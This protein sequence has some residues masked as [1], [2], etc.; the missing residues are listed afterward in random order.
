MGSGKETVGNNVPG[1]VYEVGYIC[2]EAHYYYP[3]CGREDYSKQAV[4]PS[5]KYKVD[6]LFNS[7]TNNVA[8]DNDKYKYYGE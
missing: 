5:K 4:E 1:F 7:L 3:F 8:K 2:N 6:N